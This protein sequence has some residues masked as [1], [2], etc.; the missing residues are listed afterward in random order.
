M[1]IFMQAEL[2]GVTTEQYDK[3]NAKLQSLPGN[4]FEG[5]LAHVAV[6]TASGLQIFD[7]WE[8][9]QAL[10]RFNEV[11][12]PVASEVGIPQGGT[13]KTGQVHNYWVPRA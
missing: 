5:C 1:A 10:Q 7:L 3:L 9:E 6:P 11:V 2:A 4:P 13:P 12:M 8:S